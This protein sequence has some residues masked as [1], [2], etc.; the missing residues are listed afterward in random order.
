MIDYSL[1]TVR[2]RLHGLF[3]LCCAL[4]AP[5]MVCAKLEGATM[6]WAI[7][8]TPIWLFVLAYILVVFPCFHVWED[9]NMNKLLLFTW[10]RTAWD[11][12]WTS[13]GDGPVRS[14]RFVFLCV[15]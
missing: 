15:L 2:P 10:V 9:A 8:F 13:H 4:A 7:T 3:L 12:A 11:S 1:H 14:G 6:S 5:I